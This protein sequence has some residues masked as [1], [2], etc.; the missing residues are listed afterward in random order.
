MLCAMSTQPSEP[1]RQLSIAQ[2]D[3]QLSAIV[4][5]A[6]EHGPVE[7][8]RDGEPVAVIVSLDEYRRLEGDRPNTWDAYQQWRAR[9]NLADVGIDDSFLEGLRDP[10]P[11]RDIEL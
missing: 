3:G 4:R 1:R 5:D 9:V 10:S 11:G 8:T 6:Q 7:L 2:A